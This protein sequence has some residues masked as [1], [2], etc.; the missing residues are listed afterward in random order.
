MNQK[1]IKTYGHMHRLA[2]QKKAVIYRGTAPT[3]AAWF[4]NWP[5]SVLHN[6]LAAG[7]FFEYKKPKRK[8]REWGAWLR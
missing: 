5:A 3:G 1:P 8:K 7:N 4:L 6:G 2:L